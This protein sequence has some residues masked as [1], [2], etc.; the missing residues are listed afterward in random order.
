M[1]SSLV[2]R[3]SAAF[4]AAMGLPLLFAAD[5]VLPRLV[6][7]FPHGA[8]WLGQLLAAEWLS[9]VYVISALTLLNAGQ[10]TPSLRLWA[11]P[12]GLLAGV[13]GLLLFR[14]PFDRPEAR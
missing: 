1:F 9:V 5:E 4:L 2:A 8:S 14:G 6:P 10:S 7:G 3:V 12:F 13:Y 11:V